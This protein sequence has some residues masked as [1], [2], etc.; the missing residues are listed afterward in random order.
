M[1]AAKV[2]E[3]ALRVN[4]PR[5]LAIACGHLREAQKSEAVAAG[6]VGEYVALD[7]DAESLA[8][9][10][11]EQGAI[12]TLRASIRSLLNGKTTFERGFDFIYAAGLYDYLPD[13]VACRLTSI[14]FGMLRSNGHLLLGNFHPDYPD[15]ASMEA[16]LTWWLIYR[17]E[18]QMQA[19]MSKIDAAQIHNWSTFRDEHRNLVFLEMVRQ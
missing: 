2:D 15:V 19:L 11:G 9:V 1:L 6:K 18:Q 12:R 10:Q 16:I 3:T 5:I 4:K 7:Q 8:V 17:D 13:S 14:L